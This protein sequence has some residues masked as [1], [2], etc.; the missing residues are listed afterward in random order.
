[1]PNIETAARQVVDQLAKVTEEAPLKIVAAPLPD[2]HVVLPGGLQTLKGVVTDAEVKELTGEDE[3]FISK[4]A[5]SPG[6]MLSAILQRGVVSV[7][8]QKSD[9]DML[10]M[11]LS[12][13]RDMLLLAIRKVTFGDSVPLHVRCPS[14]GEDL[15]VILSL[16]DDVPVSVLGDNPRSLIMDDLKVGTVVVTL[17][18]GAVQRQIQ[19]A[20]DKT[21]AELKTIMLFGCVNSI[22]GQPVISEGQVQKLGIQ[23]RQKIVDAIGEAN[24]GPRLQDVAVPCVFC[25]KEIALPLNLVEMFRF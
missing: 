8:G 21:S 6:K 14:C 7:G 15:E 2:T 17:P 22:N 4:T 24:P 3:E 9:K 12:G 23:D 1:V 10:D 19:E 25:E 5:M 11:L 20:A 16:T 13:D 18:T